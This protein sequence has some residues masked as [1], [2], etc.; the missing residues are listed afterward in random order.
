MKNDPKKKTMNPRL[1][2]KTLITS[3]ASQS[4]KNHRVV[5]IELAWEYIGIT[6]ERF[7][8]F[9]KIAAYTAASIACLCFITAANMYLMRVFPV[10]KP[11]VRIVSHREK[12]PAEII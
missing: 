12:K 10:P 5:T 11:T 2:R 1:F 9:G 4:K 3:R 6:K 8:F 7:R